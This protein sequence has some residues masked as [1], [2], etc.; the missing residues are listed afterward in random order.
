M[1]PDDE[2]IAADPNTGLVGERIA[3]PAGE[4]GGTTP[5]PSTS[6]GVAE[7][8]QD[9]SLP[10]PPGLDPSADRQAIRGVLS[11]VTI[12][13]TE[14]CLGMR[15]PLD[16]PPPDAMRWY[17]AHVDAIFVV[18]PPFRDGPSELGRALWSWTMQPVSGSSRGGTG[19][20]GQ[21][22]EGAP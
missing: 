7:A 2:T 19:R 20:A 6:R 16:V 3:T 9:A 15:F 13:V 1:G 4:A 22:G 17:F 11:P 10:R 12:P 5:E 21:P 18:S 14:E 8:E